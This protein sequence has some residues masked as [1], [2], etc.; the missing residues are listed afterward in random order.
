MFEFSG[1]YQTLTSAMI[2]DQYIADIIL[3]YPVYGLLLVVLIGLYRL[4][5]RTIDVTEAHLTRLINA[6]EAI[7]DEIQRKGISK[8]H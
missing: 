8:D 7:A 2:V 1:L 3:N 6:L 4:A 5:S